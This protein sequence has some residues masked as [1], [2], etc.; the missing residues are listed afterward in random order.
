MSSIW[1]TQS[2][3][4]TLDDVAT[5]LL[6][7]TKHVIPARAVRE[8]DLDTETVQVDLTKDDVADSPE[9][10]ER[11]GIDENCEAKVEEYLGGIL[12]R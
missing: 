9:Y 6:K 4:M 7:K 11:L 2:E 12:N 5:G 1:S 8:I 10:D 3:G